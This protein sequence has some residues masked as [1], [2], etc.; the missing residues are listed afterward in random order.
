MDLKKQKGVA[1]SSSLQVTSREDSVLEVGQREV[2][3]VEFHTGGQTVPGMTRKG[4]L[5][6]PE[7]SG[8][9]WVQ[10]LRENFSEE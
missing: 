9:E 8:P 1:P 5:P 4:R 7:A 3:T 10:G 2:Y 6:S